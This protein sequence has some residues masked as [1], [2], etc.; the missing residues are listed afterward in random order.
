M[1]TQEQCSPYYLSQRASSST[2]ALSTSNMN[3]FRTIPNHLMSSSAPAHSNDTSWSSGGIPFAGKQI[4]NI[5]ES[6]NER[7]SASDDLLSLDER[8]RPL[9]KEELRLSIQ[10]KRIARGLPGM[11][12]I[13]Y[14]TP[15][16]DV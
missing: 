14:K 5:E 2:S 1:M 13:E 15:Q 6:S 12:E 10:S 9:I 16:S 3:L 11:V 4:F 8:I 7:E